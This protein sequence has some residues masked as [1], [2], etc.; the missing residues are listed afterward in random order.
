MTEPE[1]KSETLAACTAQKPRMQD[2]N[3]RFQAGKG[4]R[5]LNGVVAAYWLAMF[6]GTHIPNPEAIIGPE[7]SDKLLHFS[8][9]FVLMAL[10]LMRHRL[11]EGRWASGPQ[12]WRLLA[13]V[14][15]YAAADELLQAVPGINRHADVQDALADIAGAVGAVAAAGLVSRALPD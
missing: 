4:R 9:Y 8:A 5:W 2:D 11:T 1:D 3:H 15:L 7:V 6:V 12:L 13:V 14:C 10:L